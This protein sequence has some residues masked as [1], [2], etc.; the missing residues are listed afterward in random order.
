MTLGNKV[1]LHCIVI[2]ER[3]KKGEG[4]R[5]WNKISLSGPGRQKLKWKKFPA[6]GEATVATF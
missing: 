2:Q 5:T 6:V 1:A 3:K 4:E